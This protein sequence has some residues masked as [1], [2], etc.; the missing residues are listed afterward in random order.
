MER[1]SLRE[2]NLIRRSLLIDNLGSLGIVLPPRLYSRGEPKKK[3]IDLILEAAPILGSQ[4]IISTNIIGFPIFSEDLINLREAIP[5]I[6][7]SEPLLERV[8]RK[9]PSLSL[10]LQESIITEEQSLIPSGISDDQL[11]KRHHIP[12]PEHTRMMP[13]TRNEIYR[14]TIQLNGFFSA[15]NVERIR[16][17][18]VGNWLVNQLN[19]IFN[20]PIIYLFDL[21]HPS[22]P[23]RKQNKLVY[24]GTYKLS[25]LLGMDG[26]LGM[27]FEQ[28][29]R[30]FRGPETFE[31]MCEDILNPVLQEINQHLNQFD[32]PDEL[33]ATVLNI[34]RQQTKKYFPK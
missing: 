18:L 31:K 8:T 34:I 11:G 17:Q 21:I 9:Q 5:G 10:E 33:I 30:E 20:S 13:I 26:R 32:N 2:I 4:K 12:K 3:A 27:V 25:E 16:V 6:R 24:T 1:L 22:D 28:V 15:T 7:M 23:A 29:I 19:Q 14:R